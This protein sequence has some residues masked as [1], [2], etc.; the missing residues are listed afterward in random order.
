MHSYSYPD[1][2]AN[3]ALSFLPLLLFAAIY[4]SY[5]LKPFS[6]F[7]NKKNK[8]NIENMFGS[9]FF[10]VLKTQITQKM[11]N[12]EKKKCFQRKS[13][14]CSLTYAFK[15]GSQE[16]FSRQELNMPYVSILLLKLE[17]QSSR[18]SIEI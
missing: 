18:I 3:T 9:F 16:Q 12:S 8:E 11:L 1:F 2:L 14:W 4:A 7:K 5:F 17:L 10:F 13:K 6:V 15:N